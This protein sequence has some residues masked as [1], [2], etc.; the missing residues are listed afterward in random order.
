MAMVIDNPSYLSERVGK[1]EGTRGKDTLARA[2]RVADVAALLEFPPV[3]K[4]TKAAGGAVTVAEFDALI[5]DVHLI[6][7]Q[8]AALSEAL[9]VRNSL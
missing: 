5:E 6:F 9:R 8:M 7:R 2:V 4:S 3:P 1:L